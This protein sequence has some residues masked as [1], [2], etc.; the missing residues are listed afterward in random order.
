MMQKKKKMLVDMDGVLCNYKLA[1]EEGVLEAINPNEEKYPQSRVG[2]FV[3]LPP[4]EGSIEAVKKLAEKYEI[5]ICTRPS[6][7]NLCCYTEKAIWIRKHLGYEFQKRLMLVPDKSMV[8]ADY[9][10]DDST[11]DGQTEF[12]GEFVH[13]GSPDCPNWDA[14]LNKYYY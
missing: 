3:Y 5:Y 2:F 11:K 14:V 7:P 8:I 13:Y 4:I 1:L 9:L 12:I 6:F 10:V